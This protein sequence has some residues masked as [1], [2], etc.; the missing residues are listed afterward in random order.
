MTL[1]VRGSNPRMRRLSFSAIFELNC[2]KMYMPQIN[3]IFFLN[4]SCDGE[5]KNTIHNIVVLILFKLQFFEYD[6]ILQVYPRTRRLSFLAVFELNFL[7][8][9]L[10]QIN[11]FFFINICCD[12]E[13]K[14]TIHNIVVLILFKL[15]FFEYDKILQVYLRMCRLS[16]SAVFELNFLRMYLPQK[17]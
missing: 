6:K 5:S 14:N 13:S 17:N 1:K 4:S 10:P 16:F 9:Y 11:E 12:G 8:M 3:E 15:Q 2:L 7:R